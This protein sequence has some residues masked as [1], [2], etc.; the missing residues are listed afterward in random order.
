[1]RSSSRC[2][3]GEG[4]LAALRC[5]WRYWSRG[6]RD[7]L[8]GSRTTAL[9]IG[10]AGADRAATPPESQRGDG[11]GPGDRRGTDRAAGARIDQWWHELGVA[12]GRTRRI[13]LRR[14]RPAR[15]WSQ[16]RTRRTVREH[17]GVQRVRRHVDRRRAR[18]YGPGAGSCD[19]HFARWVRCAP[20]RRTSS[21]SNEPRRAVQ[22]SV[23]CERPSSAHARC[24]R[25]ARRTPHER[26]TSDQTHDAVLVAPH[27]APVRSQVGPLHADDGRLVPLAPPGHRHD[28]Q[29]VRRRPA[30][31]ATSDGRGRVPSPTAGRADR[32]SDAVPVG[33]GRPVRRAG[34]RPPG[35][36]RPSGRSTRAVAGGRTRPLDRRSGR[37]AASTRAFLEASDTA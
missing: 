30:L 12:D 16:R 2:G 22:L 31:T 10:R 4:S 14:A 33:R 37:A 7:P 20:L 35:R 26:G 25:S 19:R 24:H 3:A 8:P 32:N 6:E 34:R 17:R 29:R 9:G 27:R 5:A 23:R 18:R 13:S 1:M 36:P 15:V 28:A 21:G 11:P